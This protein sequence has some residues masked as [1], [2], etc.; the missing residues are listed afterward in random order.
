[1][2][3]EASNKKVKAEGDYEPQN[4]AKGKRKEALVK[5][6]EEVEDV[7]DDQ[8]GPDQNEKDDRAKQVNLEMTR[9]GEYGA[10]T[11][12]VYPEVGY[13]FSYYRTS[14]VMIG[15]EAKR[16]LSFTLFM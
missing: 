1:M 6:K 14:A 7:G 2:A 12:A 15:Q 4:F 3:P 16:V 8:G 5:P 10:R 9:A 11:G 13:C